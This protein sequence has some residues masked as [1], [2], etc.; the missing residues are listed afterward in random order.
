LATTDLRPPKLVFPPIWDQVR[1]FDSDL[2]ALLPMLA[3]QVW[4][5]KTPVVRFPIRR[6]VKC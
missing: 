2:S 3:P 6:D 4:T 1:N 5:V